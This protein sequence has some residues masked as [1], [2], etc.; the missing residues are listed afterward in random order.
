MATTS[1]RL[2]YE[3]WLKLPEVVIRRDPLTA[4]VPDIAVFVGAT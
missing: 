3:E 1:K 4:R 2:T